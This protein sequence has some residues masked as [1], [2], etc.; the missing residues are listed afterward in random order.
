[1]TGNGTHTTYQNGD[2]GDGLLFFTATLFILY[3]YCHWVLKAHDKQSIFI[4]MG[5]T[6]DDNHEDGYENNN[7]K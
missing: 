4:I 1:M 3:C 5:I 2:L 7:W 6:Y